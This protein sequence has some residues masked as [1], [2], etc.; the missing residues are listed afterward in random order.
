EPLLVDAPCQCRLPLGAGLFMTCGRGGTG[1]RAALRSLW[2]KGRG[3]SSLLDRTSPAK[4]SQG[5][6]TGS[7][8]AAIRGCNRTWIDPSR[9]ID[10]SVVT[11]S[12][13]PRSDAI[14]AA[15]ADA[16]FTRIR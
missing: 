7:P 13:T 12:E 9:T 5:V 14:P 6:A 2:P 11:L 15:V 3:S 16:A 10:R 4:K 8:A 1:R